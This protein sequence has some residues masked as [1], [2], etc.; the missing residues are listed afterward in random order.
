MAAGKHLLMDTL[1]GVLKALSYRAY[2]V[3]L[4]LIFEVKL[5][6]FIFTEDQC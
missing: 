3:C 2:I 1:F 4:F 6:F 5:R